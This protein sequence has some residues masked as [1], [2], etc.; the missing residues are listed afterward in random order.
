MSVQA[1][2]W[3]SLQQGLSKQARAGLFELARWVDSRG[4]ALGVSKDFIAK[5]TSFSPRCIAYAW[6]GLQEQGLLEV[7]QTWV[8][9]LSG[10]IT[11]TRLGMHVLPPVQPSLVLPLEEY[12]FTGVKKRDRLQLAL[13]LAHERDWDEAGRATVVSELNRG[14][15]ERCKFVSA[16]LLAQAWESV[17]V[18]RA[19][20]IN[21][22]DP[23]RIVLLDAFRKVQAEKDSQ[24]RTPLLL[25]DVEISELAF[26]RKVAVPVASG[27]DASDLV[28]FE[29]LMASRPLVALV[30]VLIEGGT[31]AP[32]AWSGTL[33]VVQIAAAN[34]PAHRYQKVKEDRLL[35]GMGVMPKQA[36]EWM[37]LV[38]GA[39]GAGSKT[40][41]PDG[42][43]KATGLATW[44]GQVRAA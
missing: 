28:D 44:L 9:G 1:A 10:S 27:L 42:A 29:V 11:V 14:L 19:D 18:L 32:L 40:L 23:W 6:S 8:A 3:V 34:K 20:I 33:R 30:L 17:R 39:R 36:E 35:A 37:R 41:V 2:N 16:N 15:A 13:R 12:R 22:S 25:G 43:E 38:V 7:H 26:A 5:A 31:P 24:K 4:V 21:S